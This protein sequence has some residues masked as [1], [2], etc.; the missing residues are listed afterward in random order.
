MFN[1]KLGN[2]LGEYPSPGL[3]RGL[4]RTWLVQRLAQK[5]RA[6]GTTEVLQVIGMFDA[7]VQSTSIP[8][9]E[10]VVR[11]SQTRHTV[12]AGNLANL[13]TPGYRVRD[14]SV[15]D[16]QA[17]LREAIEARRTAPPAPSPGA[18]WVSPG[19]APVV[20]GLGENSPGQTP[21][22]SDLALRAGGDKPAIPLA[23]VAQ[24]SQSIVY[25]DESNIATEEQV[26]EM[27]KNQLQHNLAVALLASQF[28][29]LQTAISER[30]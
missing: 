22:P 28:R 11:F 26:T 15:E 13:H 30:V 16:F 3:G 8:V 14:L 18:T 23:Q 4:K 9:L 2:N 6:A 17:R 20:L 21:T 29:L 27:I 5:L 10:Q 24:N 25:H 7:I 1:R 19:L 12:L